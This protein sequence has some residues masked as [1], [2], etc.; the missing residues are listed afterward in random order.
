MKV[1]EKVVR[2]S[3][4]AILAR[5]KEINF[6][7]DAKPLSGILGVEM[8][9]QELLEQNKTFEE[10]VSAA[11]KEKLDDLI[12]RKKKYFELFEKTR[13]TSKLINEKVE[14]ES[15]LLDLRNELFHIERLK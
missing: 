13:D 12:S 15:E 11:F 4:E 2:A 8:E 9:F 7:L 10:R 5:L 3:I 6:L 1:K 14:L